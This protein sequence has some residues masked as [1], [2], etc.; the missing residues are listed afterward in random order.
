LQPVTLE[1]TGFRADPARQSKK[2]DFHQ[3]LRTAPLPIEPGTTSAGFAMQI[4]FFLPQRTIF[5]VLVFFPVAG[6]FP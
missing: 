4:I 3:R 2:V 1:V 6:Q 5:T